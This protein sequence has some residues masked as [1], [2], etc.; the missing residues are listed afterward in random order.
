[1][2]V[3]RKPRESGAPPLLPDSAIPMQ[4][5]PAPL[6]PTPPP[7]RTASSEKGRRPAGPNEVRSQIRAVDWSFAQDDTG[8]LTHDIHP[9]P[10]KFIPQIP[11]HLISLLT[12]PGDLVFDPFGGSGTTALEAIRQNRRAICVDA[13]PIGLLVG[14]VKTS[15]VPRHGLVEL[16][17]LRNSCLSASAALPPLSRM[18]ADNAHQVPDIPNLD[19]WFPPAAVAELAFIRERIS[20]LQVPAALDIA[21]L[22]LSRII[23]KSSYQ[24]SETRYASRPRTIDRGFVLSSFVQMLDEVSGSVQEAASFLTHGDCQFVH[25][26]SRAL[27]RDAFPDDTVDLVVTSPPYGNAMDYHLYHRFRLFWTGHDPRHLA[28]IEIGSHLKHQREKSGF[29]SYASDMR[30]CMA[31]LA[32][33]VRPGRHLAFVIGDSIYEGQLFGGAE[34]LLRLGAEFGLVEVTT[35]QRP[36]PTN[37]R[38]FV[39]AGRRATAE[40]IVVLR[41]PDAR[42]RFSLPPPYRLWPYEAELR[43]R[44][45]LRVAPNAEEQQDGTFVFTK[46]WTALPKLRA[47]T[48]S[49]HIVPEGRP[50]VRTWQ[51]AL[52]NGF[53]KEPASRKDPKFATHGLHPYKGKFYPQ[54]AR[55]LMSL[56][57]LEPGASVLDPFCGSGTTL[58]E[59]YLR[60]FV[61]HGCDMNPLATKI[62]RA[63]LGILQTDPDLF[64]EVIES[65]DSRLQSAP[66]RPTGTDHLRPGSLDEVRSWFPAP[67]VGK[68]NW[69]LGSI[70]SVAS[71]VIAEFL[72]VVLSSIIRDVS[73]QEPSDLRIRRRKTPLADADVAAIYATALR[74]QVR[75]VEHYW[76]VRP[77]APWDLQRSSIADGDS[78]HWSDLTRS[79]IAEG[80]VDLVVTS[81]P[82]ATALPYIDTDRLSLL[83]LFGL[84]ASDRRPLEHGLIGSRE[85][86]PSHR[87]EFEGAIETSAREFPAPTARLLRAVA[88]KMDHPK[89]GFRRRNMPALLYRYFEGMRDTLLNVARAVRPGG[90]VFMVMGDNLTSNG[91]EEIPVPTAKLVG[92]LAEA[93][94]LT[95]VETIPI[96]VTTENYKHI[97]NAI[98]DNVVLWFRR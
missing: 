35:V 50:P 37:K 95:H 1:M 92:D 58:L 73:H 54:L 43:R 22:S 9:Y 16:R 20:K 84:N 36:L 80:C 93:A 53:A 55:S 97:K 68:L 57:G 63:K 23:L 67:V 71:G 39:A 24:D 31:E 65:L 26:D 61:S 90:Q 18:L 34:L 17:E 47:L 49:H 62:A 52:E 25:A 51:A 74:E 87:A 56:S 40:S 88:A 15:R 85:I 6:P 76:S 14:R 19:K 4:A 86:T 44:E 7:H 64:Q 28:G 45:I 41:K 48:F 83:V 79:G 89:A 70:R 29:D 30:A 10:A 33:I 8:F 32:R 69:L 5:K 91:A 96:T 27:N 2:P 59:A 38:S 66:S 77:H 82:Y 42:R 81:P 78:R 98:K 13:N 11:G 46:S 12:V 60:G 72:E 94:G 21:H 3:V 75:R